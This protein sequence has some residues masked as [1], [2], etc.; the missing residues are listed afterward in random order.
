MG[1][2]PSARTFRLLVAA[3]GLAGT[4]CLTVYFAA[5][6]FTSWPYAGA[7]PDR[8][9]A[10]A[11]AHQSLFYAGAWFQATGTLLC[12]VFFLAIVQLSGA[13]GRVAGL[14][15]VVASAS[16]LA[17]VLVEGVFLVAVPQAASSGD[18]ATMA[19]AFNLSNGVFLR[20]FALAPSSATYLGLGALLV[21]SRLLPPPFGYS[22]VAIGVAFE[23]AGLVA[24]LTSAGLVL[25]IVLSVG[26]E[27]WIVAT[28][29]AIALLRDAE[30]QTA[31]VMAAAG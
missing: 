26:Q 10:Y 31:S 21:S 24:V 28:A 8:L 13:G 7:A 11:L 16:L 18:L 2:S 22:A 15:V 25:I 17:I 19:T 9:A 6:A 23:L 3:C 27:L 29:I 1:I 4:L 5:P 12:V 20:V 14:V 30:P